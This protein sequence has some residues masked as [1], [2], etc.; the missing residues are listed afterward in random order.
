MPRTDVG[1]ELA[2]AG[3]QARAHVEADA[4]HVL[5]DRAC[6]TNRAR[7]PVERGEEPVARRVDLHSAK[8]LEVATNDLV[9]TFEQ[10]APASVTQFTRS[11]G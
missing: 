10:I 9:V 6:A 5:D 4:A 1:A 2:L 11:V 7:R 8:A 3:V